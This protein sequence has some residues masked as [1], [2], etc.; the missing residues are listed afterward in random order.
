MKTQN[1]PIN[2]HI[3]RLS[4]EGAALET[5]QHE[6]EELSAASHWMLPASEFHH[7][8]NNL[9]YDNDIKENVTN[10]NFQTIVGSK[11]MLESP[12]TAPELHGNDTTLRRAQSQPKHHKLQQSHFAPW[13]ARHGKNE[14]VPSSCAKNLDSHEEYIFSLRACRNQ[15]PQFI[16]QM[17][18]GS[19]EMSSF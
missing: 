18:F 14:L 19:E 8:W 4:F 2:I 1:V 7:L 9:Y 17:V 16:L 3:Y 10:D 15:Q 13:T 12:S 5:L 6:N 11:L